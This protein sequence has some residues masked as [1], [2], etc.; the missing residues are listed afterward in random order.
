M[1]PAVAYLTQ[2]A[3]GHIE[4]RPRTWFIGGGHMN[5]AQWRDAL[6]SFGVRA[7]VAGLTGEWGTAGMQQTAN[8]FK[9]AQHAF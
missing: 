4:V 1:V 8:W 9:A 7:C 5:A 6:G 2:V 3:D